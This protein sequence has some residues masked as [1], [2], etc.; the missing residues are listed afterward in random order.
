MPTAFEWYDEDAFRFRPVIEK[1][2]A[3][4]LSGVYDQVP[5][6]RS[7]SLEVAKRSTYLFSCVT[8]VASMCIV[9]VG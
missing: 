2:L 7:G 1:L 6:R 8:F 4:L 9:D 5:A 3:L